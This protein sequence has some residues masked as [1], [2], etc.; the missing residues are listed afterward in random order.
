PSLAEGISNTLLE[1]MATG[2]P[3]VATRVG[4][5]PELVAEG[6]TGLLVPPGDPEALGAALASLAADGE[7]RRRF[8]AAARVR[9]VERFS[10]EAMVARYAACYTWA[11]GG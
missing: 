10:L 6:E 11:A 9:A 2:L 4:G 3:V 8:G 5:N 1:A 7:R